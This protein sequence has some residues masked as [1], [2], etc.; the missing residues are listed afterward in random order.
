VQR[1][2]RRIEWELRRRR[3]AR[4]IRDLVERGVV[5]DGSVRI[6]SSSDVD[7]KTPIRIGRRTTSQRNCVFK[8]QVP[9]SIGRYCSIGEGVHIIS[10]NHATCRASLN[11][12]HQR[13]MGMQDLWQTQGPVRIGHN[14]WLGDNAT[15]L[16]GVTIGNGAIVGTNSVVTRHVEPFAVVAGS[17][18]RLIRK[19]FSEEVIALLEE[20]AWWNMSEAEMPRQL[21]KR[22]L[23]TDGAGEFLRSLLADR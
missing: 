16:S 13:R 19:R 22:D 3:E 2:K 20:I 10:S 12:S 23:T 6:L 14:V 9:I 15:V 11:P 4:F 7:P 21:F 8:G 18:A 1:A 5:E 17:P